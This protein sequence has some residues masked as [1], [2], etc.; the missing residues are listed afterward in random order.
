MALNIQD[1]DPQSSVNTADVTD[2]Y[3]FAPIDVRPARRPTRCRSAA[4]T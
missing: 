1:G 3:L 2:C 4:V